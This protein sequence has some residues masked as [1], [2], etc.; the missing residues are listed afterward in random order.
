MQIICNK[1]N[2]LHVK[3]MEVICIFLKLSAAIV[4]TPIYQPVQPLFLIVWDPQRLESCRSHPPLQRGRHP[5]PKLLQ[6]YSLSYPAFLK[7]FESQ[8]KQITDHLE[9][10]RTFSTMQSG[11]RAGHGCTSAK[12][13]VLN[14][15]ITVI[16]K[17]HYCA[18]VFRS[19]EHTSE[20][21]SL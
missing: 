4:A 2:F 18:A 1:T 21:Q 13:K 10:H 15:I 9:S 11:I 7:V 8:A 16:D 12:L 5:G 19:E 17:R 20:L 6:T 14:D 3:K